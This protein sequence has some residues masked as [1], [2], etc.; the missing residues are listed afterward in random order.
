MVT[1]VG[2]P[3]CLCCPSQADWGI[4]LSSLTL[5]WLGIITLNLPLLCLVSFTDFSPRLEGN[6][7]HLCCG[8]GRRDRLES[9]AER[10]TNHVQGCTRKLPNFL[11]SLHCPAELV[12]R[13]KHCWQEAPWDAW[14][15]VPIL[16]I[17]STAV[18]IWSGLQVL[19][20]EFPS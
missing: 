19:G 10:K 20:F 5:P 16:H 18:C 3:V 17:N 12:P 11:A 14:S 9:L 4:P 2:A 13:H 1:S 6:K 15:T 8:R 7:P